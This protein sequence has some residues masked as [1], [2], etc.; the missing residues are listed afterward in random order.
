MSVVSSPASHL[1][2]KHKVSLP[3]NLTSEEVLGLKKELGMENKSWM[4]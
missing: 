4:A 2:L 1:K 3:C